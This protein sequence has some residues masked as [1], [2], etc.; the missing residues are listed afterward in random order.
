V[1]GTSVLCTFIVMRYFWS[2]SIFD[3]SEH[4]AACTEM[5]S[6]QLM[7]PC[8]YRSH[9]TRVAYDVGEDDGDDVLCA[10]LQTSTQWKGS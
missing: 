1:V 5:R 7:V 3:R 4:T 10:R 8:T 6:G 2:H 9:N